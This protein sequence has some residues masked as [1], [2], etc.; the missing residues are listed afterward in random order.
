MTLYH[1][2]TGRNIVRG[3]AIGFGS[4]VPE[5]LIGKVVKAVTVLRGPVYKPGA[6][7]PFPKGQDEVVSLR[8]T[9]QDRRSYLVDPDAVVTFTHRPRLD[10]RRFYLDKRWPLRAPFEVWER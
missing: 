3:D 1:H 7:V 5:G 6:K 8:V 2:D 4:N 10:V 9:T